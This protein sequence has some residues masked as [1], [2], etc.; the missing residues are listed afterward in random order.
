LA[1]QLQNPDPYL[2]RFIGLDW[3]TYT[4]VKPMHSLKKYP[5]YK[6]LD[7]IGV[8]KGKLK[9]KVINNNK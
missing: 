7:I 9:K 1:V 8:L 3:K 6:G 2:T 4:M 5:L